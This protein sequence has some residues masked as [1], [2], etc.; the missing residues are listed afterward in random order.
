M[1]KNENIQIEKYKKNNEENIINKVIF[2]NN[3]L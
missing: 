1:I 2:R 3:I